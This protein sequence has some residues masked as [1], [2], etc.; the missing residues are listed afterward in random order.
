MPLHYH[1][2]GA[3]ANPAAGGC[4]DT[5][6]RKTGQRVGLSGCHGLGGNQVFAIT[7]AR[8]IMADDNC[9]DAAAAG[10]SKN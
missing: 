4:L 10:G 2:L 6:S 1:H 7:R 9:L 8:Q 5:M 3:I